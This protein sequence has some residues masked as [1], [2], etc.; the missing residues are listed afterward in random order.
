[1]STEMRLKVPADISQ[2]PKVLDWVESVV[3]SSQIQLVVEEIF[4]NICSYAYP[5]KRGE[6]EIIL[7]K[8]G[9]FVEIEFIDEGLEFNPLDYRRQKPID[10]PGGFG[11]YIVNHLMDE[12]VYERKNEQN[13]LKLKK[14]LTDP[15][16]P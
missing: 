14:N 1:M 10:E 15:P 13:S 11:I 12:V 8:N 6:V 3:T 9:G 5:D 2:Y 4:I 7:K 16:K